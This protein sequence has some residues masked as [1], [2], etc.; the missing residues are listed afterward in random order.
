[1]ALVGT[2]VSNTRH[3]LVVQFRISLSPSLSFFLCEIEIA[4]V[5]LKEVTFFRSYNNII[6]NIISREFCV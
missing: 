4:D 3:T 6:N 2:L 5:V 1:M